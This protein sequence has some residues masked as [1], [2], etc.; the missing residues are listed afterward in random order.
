MSRYKPIDIESF[1]FSCWL[2]DDDVSGGGAEEFVLLSPD[3]ANDTL[4]TLSV[5]SGTDPT[6]S[7]LSW[8]EYPRCLWLAAEFMAVTACAFSISRALS[9]DKILF[10]LFSAGFSLLLLFPGIFANIVLHVTEHSLQKQQAQVVTTN[11]ITRTPRAIVSALENAIMMRSLLLRSLLCK[12]FLVIIEVVQ[13][14]WF[15]WIFDI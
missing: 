13:Q 14:V 11:R 10:T 2:D 7:M 6:L 3:G 9:L 12:C 4:T 15:L 5:R 8:E 1:S